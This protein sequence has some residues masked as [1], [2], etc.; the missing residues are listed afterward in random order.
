MKHLFTTGMSL[1]LLLTIVSCQNAAREPSRS[2]TGEVQHVVI[3][4]LKNPGDEAGRHALMNASRTLNDIP[5]V[6][7][8]RVGRALPS[9]RPVVDNS[10][11]IAMVMTFKNEQALRA[12]DEHPLHVSAV[13]DV[14]RPLVARYIIYDFVDER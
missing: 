6:T 1:L 13:R 4:W 14:L 3:C 7:S 10:Y 5:G 8:V 12:Y 2:R 11:D 9:T